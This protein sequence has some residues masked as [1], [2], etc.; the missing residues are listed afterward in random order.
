MSNVTLALRTTHNIPE[1]AA[2]YAQ[3]GCVRINGLFPDDVA[4]SIHH[5]L[6]NKTP[7]HVVHA[8]SEGSHL[9]YRPEDWAGLENKERQKIL[10]NIMIQASEGFSYFYACYP[11]IQNYLE[12]RD[13]EW[14]LHAMTEYLN[15]P[16]FHNFVKSITNEPGVNKIDG[17]ATLYASGHFLNLH[18]DTGTDAE[19]R[20]AYVMGFTKDWSPNWGGQLL[21]LDDNDDTQFGFSPSFN[22]LTLFKVPRKHMVTQVAS[23]AKGGRYSITGWLRDD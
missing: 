15:S 17:Q 21:M 6:A 2:S 9:Y 13:P 10:Q 11:M 19:R 12:Q 18:D 14:P 8:D 22:S 23:F 5:D 1:L 20:V 3:N 4:Q 16:E 7:W